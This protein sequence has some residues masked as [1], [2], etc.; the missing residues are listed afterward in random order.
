MDDIFYRASLISSKLTWKF[1]YKKKNKDK[2]FNSIRRCEKWAISEYGPRDLCSQS[3]AE[4]GLCWPLKAERRY[5]AREPI[6]HDVAAFLK[7]A[8]LPLGRMSDGDA[9]ACCGPHL[10]RHRAKICYF[11]SR[12][13]GSTINGY[14]DGYILKISNDVCLEI[15]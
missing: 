13:R 12:S 4:Y 8:P 6:S 14:D 2:K 9:Q 5:L 7:L 11:A 3:A 1:K 15:T 10:H